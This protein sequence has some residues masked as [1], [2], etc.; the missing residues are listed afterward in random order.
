MKVD[1]SVKE[2]GLETDRMDCDV[3]VVEDVVV[4]TEPEKG[5]DAVPR[6][7]DF[8]NDSVGD[9]EELVENVIDSDGVIVEEDDTDEDNVAVAEAV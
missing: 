6:D 9:G 1:S 7:S 2:L 4:V 3:D 8:E 5:R